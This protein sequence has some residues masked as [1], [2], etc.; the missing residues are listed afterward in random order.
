MHFE[1]WCWFPKQKSPVRWSLLEDNSGTF[2][3]KTV[4]ILNQIEEDNNA[5]LWVRLWRAC[6]MSVYIMKFERFQIFP[7]FI[8]RII[9]LSF[10]CLT[11]LGTPP[12][13]SSWA[14]FNCPG[15]FHSPTCIS[16]CILTQWTLIHFLSPNFKHTSNTA[17]KYK[18]GIQGEGCVSPSSQHSHIPVNNNLV[19]CMYVSVLTHLIYYILFIH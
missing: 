19:L 5:Y 13:Q 8:D 9:F 4:P 2:S 1:N 6:Y 3:D 16:Y 12:F 17:S 11:I 18:I 10:I 7:L 14:T 15:R